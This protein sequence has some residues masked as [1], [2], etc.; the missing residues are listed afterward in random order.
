MKQDIQLQKDHS[1]QLIRVMKHTG[2]VLNILV[3]FVRRMMGF[4][5]IALGK[6]G[7]R[8][9]KSHEAIVS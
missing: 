7:V 2:A 3:G 9:Q 8:V 5:C 4:G 6:R 1:S